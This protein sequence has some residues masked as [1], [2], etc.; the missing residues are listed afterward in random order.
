MWQY[1]DFISFVLC[2][3]TI[4]VACT[5]PNISIVLV[6]SIICSFSAVYLS[7]FYKG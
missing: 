5:V 7:F 3:I 2:F 1:K 4:F 6:V